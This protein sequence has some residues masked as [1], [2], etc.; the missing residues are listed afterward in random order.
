MS[1]R[2]A[3][4]KFVALVEKHGITVEQGGKHMKVLH[5]GKTVGTLSTSGESNA[6]KQAIR[7]LDRQ[8]LL[9]EDG[10]EARKVVF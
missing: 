10:K 4:K 3:L 7:D 2:Q 9:G 5:N 8:G 6:L 1:N